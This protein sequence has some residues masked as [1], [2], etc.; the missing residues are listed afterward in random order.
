MDQY[1]PC[2][3]AGDYPIL[4]RPLTAAEYEAALHLAERYRLRRLDGRI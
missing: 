1:H 2:Y 4:E 3:R